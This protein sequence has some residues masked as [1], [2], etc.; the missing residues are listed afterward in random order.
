MPEDTFSHGATH[1]VND[2]P[3]NQPR[4][5]DNFFLF[6]FFLFFFFFF[7]DRFLSRIKKVC[8][9]YTDFARLYIALNFRRTKG[10]IRKPVFRGTV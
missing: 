7:F 3:Q 9:M 1:I 10:D 8:T 4:A 5:L 6:L 2:A